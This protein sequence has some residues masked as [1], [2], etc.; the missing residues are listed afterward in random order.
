MTKTLHSFF[1]QFKKENTTETT[2][3]NLCRW[4]QIHLKKN[5]NKDNYVQS[6]NNKKV[7]VMIKVFYKH[8]IKIQ[9]MNK[10]NPKFNNNINNNQYQ[11]KIKE[12]F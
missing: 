8:K 10:K 12:L 9:K 1:H 2:T 7:I 6:I 3:K 4:E 11:I 5:C